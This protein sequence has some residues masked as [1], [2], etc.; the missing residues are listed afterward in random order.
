MYRFVLCA[1]T[2]VGGSLLGF[3]QVGE[4]LVPLETNPY[5]VKRNA[6]QKAGVT[7]F[8]STFIYTPDTLALPLFDEFSRNNFQLYNGDPT[9]VGVTSDKK[10]LLLDVSDNPLPLDVLF[11]L[12]PTYR[13]EVNQAAGTSLSSELTPVVIKMGD[14]SSYPPVYSSVEVYP[15]YN[16]VDTLDFVNDTDTF[17][18]ASGLVSQDSAIQFFQTLQDP[19]KYWLDDFAYHNYRFA[20]NPWSLGVVTFDGINQYGYPYQFGTAATGYADYLTSK[21]LRLNGYTGQ[22]SVYFSF[23]YQKGGFGDAPEDGDSLV[24]EF[25]SPQFDQ[26]SR[27]WSV[28]GGAT[29]DF[30]LVHFPVVQTKYLQKGFQF[31]FVNYGGL[32]GSLDHFHIDYV[33][34]RALSGYQDTLLK[35]F[36]FV[37]PV[38]SLLKDYTAVPWD[39]YKESPQNRMNDQVRI[40]VRNGSNIQEN[41]QNGEVRISYDGT[42]ENTFSLSNFLLTNQDPGQNYAPR[43][44]YESFHDF[45]TGTRFDETKLGDQQVFGL[46]A[47]V[48]AQFPNFAPN[49]SSYNWQSFANYYAYDDGSAEKAYGVYGAQAR[50]A[51]R[52]TPYVAD[53]LIGVQM[54]FVPTVNDLSNKLF[55]LTVWSDNNGKPGSVLYQD[56]F[57][58]PREP[59][60]EST[61]NAFTT[62]FLKDTM[63]LPVSG[64]FYVGW[65]QVDPDRLNIGFDLNTDASGNL[66]YSLDQENT[67]LPSQFAGAIMMRPLFSTALDASLGLP[68][69]VSQLASFSVYPNPTTD[70]LFVSGENRE[71]Q[72]FQV[73]DLQGKVWQSFEWQGQAV[74]VADLQP[75]MYFLRATA[76]GTTV[77]FLKQ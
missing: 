31:R 60:Y 30:K 77:K 64:T 55:L 70:L 19:T 47:N 40:T 11:S 1:L 42:V 33:H 57:F 34:L 65:R 35:D 56:D 44:V 73:V 14:F 7:T 48:S 13:T 9:A 76:T 21:P 49:D 8:D 39:H 15:P 71:G 27:V 38:G 18:V 72:T 43:T 25:Y 51:Y 17:Y 41:S 3:S 23:L 36:A 52:F 28:N 26:W 10:Y 22:D 37:Y 16:L 67:W 69:Q 2:L 59:Q 45:S 6:V 46:S 61:R 58:F 63:K 54:H 5:L 24:L 68:S 66:F 74:S 75:G 4:Q 50:V 12:E 53:S 29:E 20:V 62:Y 32:S